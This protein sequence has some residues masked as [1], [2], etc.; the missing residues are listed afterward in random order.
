MTP[1]HK[2]QSDIL[3]ALSAHQCTP[4][5]INV[6]K[7]KTVDGRYFSTGVKPGYP[8]ISGFRWSDGKAFFIEVKTKTGRPRK[9]QIQFHKMLTSHHIVHGIA[10]SVDDALKIVNEGLVGYG[11]KNYRG[12]LE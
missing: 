11:F 12:E 9:E 5:R 8:D 3:V 1:E 10:R 6:G 4:F 7:G 2:I